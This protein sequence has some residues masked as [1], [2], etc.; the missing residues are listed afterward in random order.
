MNPEEAIVAPTADADLESSATTA[1]TATDAAAEAAGEAE[2]ASVGEEEVETPDILTQGTKQPAEVSPQEQG[3]TSVLAWLKRTTFALSPGQLA[4]KSFLLEKRRNEGYR[5]LY[6]T[7]WCR[8][9]TR[10]LQHS[11]HVDISASDLQSKPFPCTLSLS[12]CNQITIKKF[13]N[14]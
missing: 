11:M 5:K 12:F 13:N 9:Q 2:A 1:A 4:N 3:R 8:L 10:M 7:A 14:D 6:C